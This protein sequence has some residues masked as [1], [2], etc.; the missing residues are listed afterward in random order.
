MRVGS[1]GG[2]DP[3][4]EGMATHFSI[5]AWR[6]PWTAKPGGLQSTGLQELDMTWQ[7]D[8]CHCTTVPYVRKPLR[9]R[10]EPRPAGPRS[11]VG[12]AR[13]RCPRSR[14]AKVPAL[15]PAPG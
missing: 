12:K 10:P 9:M 11:A 2:E 7:L 14:R 4:E 5:L 8:Y 6:I 13:R 1:L 15:G 3:L